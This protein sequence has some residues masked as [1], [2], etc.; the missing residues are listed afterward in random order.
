M[1]W[2][3]NN[4]A[5]TPN[6]V[7]LNI[8]RPLWVM[9]YLPATVRNTATSGSIS[10]SSFAAKVDFATI[11]SPIS[12]II[13]DVDGDGKPDLLG[14]NYD[15]NSLSVLRNIATSGSISASSF[16]N[17]I[18][19]LTDTGPRSVCVG[20]LDGDGKPDIAVVNNT[21]N[22]VSV[23]HNP[24]ISSPTNISRPDEIC[25]NSTA[26]LSASCV[27][28][29]TPTWYPAII[30]ITGPSKNRV[31][32][33]PLFVGSPF[34][35]PPLASTKAYLVRCEQGANVSP[36]APVF[37]YV[38][39][40]PSPA[41]PTITASGPT[42]FCNGGSVT[43]NSNVSNNNAINFVK[44]I[45]QYV[46]VPHSA[47]INLSTTFTMEAWVKYSGSNSTIVD[48]GNYD[49]LWELN[50]NSNGNKLG[51]YERNTGWK[52][53]TGIVPENIWTHVAI[54][55]QSGTL[56]FYINGVASGTAAVASAFQDTEPMNIGRQQPTACVCNHFNGSMDE[57][58]L[59]NV[60]RTQVQLQSN[61]TNS[62]PTNS[63]GLVAYY[64]FDEGTGTTTADATGNGNNGT[65]INS[66]GLTWQVS[67]TSP[68]VKAVLWSPGGATTPSIV[69]TTT[70][71]YTATVTNGYGCSTST[72][73]IVNVGSN[74]A[75]VTLISPTD[76]Y[77]SSTI[78][79]TASIVNGKITATNKVTGT[80]KVD[81]KAKSVQ[82]N[83]GFKAD[84]GTVFSAA[85]GGCN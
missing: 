26:T 79:K 14:S 49:F 45:S 64:K 70:G 1:P 72:S 9:R 63:A 56:T 47:S 40:N 69:A 34:T 43:L 33:T 53:S 18:N 17:R 52:Y 81:Y 8:C 68:V 19:L 32:E 22:T 83:A 59:W 65:L 48:K 41:A 15:D 57:L 39:S 74:A 73:T 6:M 42:T 66:N 27:A 11:T 80:A 7:G 16:K 38:N 60:V 84:N 50:A 61:M 54:T 78:V 20:D 5:V 36:N 55:L 82:L 85:V 35:T 44:T 24:Y 58:R 13:S 2:P 4:A 67:S 28:G 10:A 12:I 62:V 31:A 75:L 71:T 23:I 46:T 51:Y 21:A 76:D 25:M 77:S 30:I 29:A 37:V 3:S